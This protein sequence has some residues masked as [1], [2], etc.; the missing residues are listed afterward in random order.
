MNKKIIINIYNINFTFLLSFLRRLEFI[1][2][3]II[4]SRFHGNDKQDGNDRDTDIAYLTINSV[5]IKIFLVLFLTTIFVEYGY[6]EYATKFDPYYTYTSYSLAFLPERSVELGTEQ[7][8]GRI[9]RELFSRSFIPS[10]MLLEL[11]CNPVQTLAAY[12]RQNYTGFYDSLTISKNFNLI[13]SICAGFEEPWAMSVFLGEII[14]FKRNADD[15]DYIGVGYSGFLVSYGDTHIKDNTFISD[16]WYQ[17]EWKIRGARFS[18]E[19]KLVWSFRLGGKL[20]GN[21]NIKTVYFLS[22][23]RNRT[24]YNYHKFSLIKNIAYSYTIDLDS[25][26]LDPIRHYFLVSKKFPVGDYRLAIKLEL[27]FVWERSS[28]YTGELN[29]LNEGD[30]F[31]FIIRPNVEF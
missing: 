7:Q 31:Q 22:F 13:R 2:G 28:K 25:R 20:H 12:I 26:N 23:D 14:G 4:D 11:S 3:E 16:S 19:Q 29:P 17:Y 1:V 21:T 9:Y 15:P 10:Y 8:E 27:G 24:D 6:T 5:V 18:E 30:R